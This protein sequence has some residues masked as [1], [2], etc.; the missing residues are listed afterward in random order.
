MR[1]YF[2]DVVRIFPRGE[3]RSPDILRRGISPK[4]VSYNGN[5]TVSDQACLV[6]LE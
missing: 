6:L 1:G 3:S 5:D 2:G 4:A